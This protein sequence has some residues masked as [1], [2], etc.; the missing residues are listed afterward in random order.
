M[1]DR[2]SALKTGLLPFG[3]DTVRE[4]VLLPFGRDTVQK[5]LY[6]VIRISPRWGD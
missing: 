6:G 3:R 1:V 2:F 4:S 5:Y